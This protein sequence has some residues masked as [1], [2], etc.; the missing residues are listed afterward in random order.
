MPF[1]RG[2]RDAVAAGFG[3][4]RSVGFGLFQRVLG[5]MPSWRGLR[6]AVKVWGDAV[7]AGFGR[8]RSGWC[9]VVPFR[10]GGYRSSGFGVMPTNQPA[11]QPTSIAA[12]HPAS[13]QAIQPNNQ[14]T[15]PATSQPTSQATGSRG[16]RATFGKS[17]ATETCSR[18]PIFP[19]QRYVADRKRSGNQ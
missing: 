6:D 16:G 18:N 11:S 2:L 3:R 15:Q 9:W 10:R 5:E 1:R 19:S 12:S 8:C 13:Q 17:N 14:P 7:P 4:C